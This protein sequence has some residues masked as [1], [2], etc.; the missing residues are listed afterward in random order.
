MRRFTTSILLLLF[1]LAATSAGATTF[2]KDVRHSR[3]GFISQ[4]VVWLFGDLEIP[5][6]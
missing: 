3:G 1:M 2:E 5:L 4:I 6:P